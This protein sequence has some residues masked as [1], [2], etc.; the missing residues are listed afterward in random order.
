M[1]QSK[2]SP[3]LSKW[4]LDTSNLSK[5]DK[6]V[7]TIINFPKE[8]GYRQAAQMRIKRMK[9]HG[10]YIDKPSVTINDVVFVVTEKK[11]AEW[12]LEM[13]SLPP[14][15]N[16]RAIN[17]LNGVM[18][19]KAKKFV[20]FDAAAMDGVLDEI[21]KAFSSPKPTASMIVDKE[22]PKVESEPKRA[23]RKYVLSDDEKDSIK[24]MAYNQS[25]DLKEMSKELGAPQSV[26]KEYL[27]SLK[28]G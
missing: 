15:A 14:N 28:N 11:N 27:K 18:K 4:V 3:D 2:L 16:D 10:G 17:H 21:L 20:Y 5:E 24:D 7:L 25:K 6:E 26:I 23:S 19:A 1:L 8:L 9:A 22:K 13:H 12:W